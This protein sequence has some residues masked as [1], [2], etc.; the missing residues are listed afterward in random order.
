M[1]HKQTYYFSIRRHARIDF[2]HVYC[3]IHVGVNSNSHITY[4]DL[5]SVQLGC[6][7]GS[8]IR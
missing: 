7:V 2:T 4:M 6:P 1:Y 8:L 3:F 5:S